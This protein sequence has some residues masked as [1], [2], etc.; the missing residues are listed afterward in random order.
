MRILKAAVLGLAIAGFAGGAAVAE[1]SYHKDKSAQTTT[2][3]TKQTTVSNDTK[4]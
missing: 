2:P 1:C 4:K 3:T